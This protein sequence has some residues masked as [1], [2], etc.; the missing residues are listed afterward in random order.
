[1]PDTMAAEQDAPGLGPTVTTVVALFTIRDDALHALLVPHGDGSHALPGG[2]PAPAEGL[3]AAARRV[4]ATASGAQHVWLEQ[5]Y[6]FGDPQRDPRRAEVAVAWYA[7]VADD[8]APHVPGHRAT[9]ASPRPADDVA[10]AAP[11][12]SAR[13]W[14]VTALPPLALDHRRIVDYAI[15]RLRN[16]LEYTT[17][18]FQ[19]LPARFTLGELQ[20]V[21]EAILGRALDKRNFRR[22][23]EVLGIVRPTRE[24]RRTGA[25]RPAQLWRFAATEA[26]EAIGG[27]AA[28]ASTS[29]SSTIATVTTAPVEP[30]R[31]A[32]MSP[33]LRRGPSRTAVAPPDG[34][35]LASVTSATTPGHDRG[36]AA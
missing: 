31:L 13:W 9:A 7:L 27:P 10:P 8:R 19:L 24:M 26:P 6:T 36:S 30:L 33:S 34:E 2:A 5:L 23:V 4:L 1:M 25:T 28:P 18:G 3:D 22:R 16:K 35:S 17:V 12:L 15:Q 29:T 32:R 14:P 11:A 21:Y 20:R